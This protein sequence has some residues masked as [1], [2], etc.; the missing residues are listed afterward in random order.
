M[1]F[2]DKVA[3]ITA[4][5]SGIGLACAHRLASEGANVVNADIRKPTTEAEQTLWGLPGECKWIEADMGD[6]RV[7][8]A[9]VEHAIA[10]WGGVD[11]LI[12]N[13]ALVDDQDGAVTEA[14][15]EQWERQFNVTV[16]GTF[17]MTKRCIPEMIKRGGGAIVN[18]SSIGG[19]NPFGMTA[20][21]STAKAAILQLTRSVAIDYGLNKVRCNAVCPGATDT[22][23]FSVIKNNPYELADRETRTA[24]GRIGQ[25]NEVAAAIAFLASDDASYI[26]GATLVVD[27]GWSVSQWNPRMGPRGVAS[28][29]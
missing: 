4:G 28:P 17:L 22:P 23:T 5:S 2:A 26:T 6:V 8:D 12:N 19:L 9:I 16:R 18:T 21:Y 14:K 11:V 15:L 10:L 1:R 25:P 7:P 13:A 24:L 29:K 3:L 20:A 27:G